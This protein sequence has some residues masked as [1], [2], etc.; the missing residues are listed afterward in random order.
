MRNMRSIGVDLETPMR[1][2][3]L[4]FH[5]SRPTLFGLEMHLARMHRLVQSF[6]PHAVV[7]D[8]V[9]SFASGGNVH[10]ASQMLLRLVDF[11]KSRGITAFLNG[12]VMPD[13]PF[14]ADIGISSVIDTWL[15]LRELESNGERNRGLVV[16]KSR[17]MAHSNQIREFVLGPKGIALHDVYVGPG[18][19]LTGS[20]RL[21]QE[22]RERDE[23]AQRAAEVARHQ[24][25]L[26]LKRRVL[27]AQ[28][29]ALRASYAADEEVI[30]RA[31]RES[32]AHEARVERDRDAMRSSRGV[33]AN[34]ARPPRRAGRV[35][36]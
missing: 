26:D 36:R 6:A 1:R 23:A 34:G 35:V 10:D 7:I 29:A 14:G 18:G 2:G 12:L 15:L 5:A 25:E 22:A 30:R 32:E 21:A 27:E 31:L 28:I 24:G 9:S 11:L 17:G 20:S 19:V 4:Q 13:G 3:L 8:P 33:E 16:L